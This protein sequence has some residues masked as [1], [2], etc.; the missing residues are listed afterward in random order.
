MMR[1]AL[2]LFCCCVVVMR[3]QLGCGLGVNVHRRWFA[4]SR[5]YDL[6]QDKGTCNFMCHFS[7]PSKLAL[8]SFCSRK[9]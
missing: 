9:T 6:R 1:D 2:V 4:C 5:L 8:W 3:E 7:M